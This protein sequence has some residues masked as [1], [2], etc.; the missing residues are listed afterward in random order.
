MKNTKIAKC[1]ICGDDFMTTNA[2]KAPKTCGKIVCSKSR[3]NSKAY[4]ESLDKR[5]AESP[6][7][8]GFYINQCKICN[9]QFK[10]KLRKVKYCGDCS[11]SAAK[12]AIDNLQ[13]DVRRREWSRLGAYNSISSRSVSNAELKLGDMIDQNHIKNDRQFL[14]G[15]EI[16]YLYDN[17]A[18]EYHGGWHYND[19]HDHYKSTTERD[20]IKH[21]M[22][23]SLGV[24]HY[25]VGW[26]LSTKH[27]D[28]FLK[29]HAYF[30]NQAASGSVSPFL[31]DFDLDKFR[32]E[33]DLLCKT[34][35]VFGYLCNDIVNWYHNYRWFQKTSTHN[36][37]A[38]DF[39]DNNQNIVIDNRMKYAD[40][41]PVSLR[42]YFTLFDYTPS[43]FPEILA[44]RLASEI[45]GKVVV[46]PFAGYGNRMLGVCAAGKEY[47]GYDINRLSV[48]AN[49]LIV[50]DIGL[51]ANVICGD[52][53]KVCDDRVYDGLITCPPYLNKDDYGVMS[54]SDYYDM[55]NQV[56]HRFKFTGHG[57]VVIKPSLVDFEKFKNAVGRIVAERD[58]NWGGL[59]RRSIHKIL[60][61]KR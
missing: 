48:N 7:Q 41:R 36:I 32:Y 11:S 28:D 43:L 2:K 29:Q 20:M 6:K 57:F 22:L 24:R 45:D 53:S 61:L 49:N 27:S 44:K 13:N 37:S 51:N 21:Q 47:V 18:V 5:R 38:V 12:R 25:V 14:N 56:F 19:F 58:S 3:K 54:D 26:C 60:V 40:C 16:D 55:I 52:S 4:K 59:G 30:I 10:A 34:R 35:G 46:D 39:W 50:H 15:Y 1:P 17:L 23:K 8:N 33:F 42:R 9:N 31:F